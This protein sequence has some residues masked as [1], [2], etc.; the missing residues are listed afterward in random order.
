MSLGAFKV[1]FL[2]FVQKES[3]VPRTDSLWKDTQELEPGAP[4]GEESRGAPRE[5]ELLPLH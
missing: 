5:M 1:E 3:D 2:S 4:S